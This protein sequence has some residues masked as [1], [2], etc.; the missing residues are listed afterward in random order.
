MRPDERTGSWW[1]GAV[2]VIAACGGGKGP[3]VSAGEV[4]AMHVQQAPLSPADPAWRRAPVHPARLLL[5]DLV[6][7]RLLEPSTPQVGVQ[8]LED[9][10]RIAFRLSW[11]DPTKDDLPGAARFIDACAVQ[12]PARPAAD[13]PAPQMGEPGKPVEISFW[14]AALQ[15]RVDGRADDIHTL[16]PNARVDHYPFEA[17][18]IEKG[19]PEQVAMAVRYRPAEAVGNPVAVPPA[20]PVQDLIA[21]G[22]GTL[23]P[24]A[25]GA[26]DA[27][28]RHDGGGWTVVVVRT[29][30]DGV[31]AAVRG[32]VAFAVWEG[33]KQE[34]G[35]RK[36]RTGWIP[37]VLG[38]AP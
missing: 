14:S 20:R 4:R 10:R 36:M 16:Y 31:S 22:P 19:S 3:G 27:M 34:V 29:L 24:A 26:S 25:A 12:L 32:Q 17:A 28:G 7:P 8:A 1:L 38:G 9:G 2:L 23:R 35:A 11:S 6:E 13:V 33:A 30:P 37:L 18:A 15:A 21:E 5:Q